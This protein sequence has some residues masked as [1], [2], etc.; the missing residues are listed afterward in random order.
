MPWDLSTVNLDVLATSFFLG[1]AIII[2]SFSLFSYMGLLPFSPPRLSSFYSAKHV[3]ITGGSSGIGKELARILISAGASVTLVAR[4][5]D[6][7]NTAA[8]ELQPPGEST[9]TAKR[10]N[11]FSADCSEYAAVDAMVDH[12]ESQFGP[13]DVLI[14]SAGSSSGGYFDTIDSSI[15]SS[16]MDSNYFAQAYPA[17]AIFKRMAARRAGSICFISSMA[18]Q[19]GVF[20]MSA[21]S[22]TKFALRG[23]AE[24]LYFEGKPFGINIT[25]AFP[26]DTDTPGFH[27]ERTTLPPETVEI[28]NTGGLFSAERV[29]SSVAYGIMRKR[30]N[31]T[32][33]LIGRLLGILTAGL[34]PGL[35]IWDVLIIP[36]ARAI[37]PF[38]L[39]DQNSVIR[40]GHAVRFPNPTTTHTTT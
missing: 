19:T 4:N 6:R 29:A 35:S 3:L 34:T 22:P 30:F 38:F 7:L 21:Y 9:A 23:L 28:S 14:N 39:W 33:G 37:T 27:A 11:V 1:G 8:K 25:I 10:I 15:I 12:V 5:S 20:G 16:Q 13:I 31:V 2:F 17:H 26:P 24:S 18:G 40:K 32:V 36:I